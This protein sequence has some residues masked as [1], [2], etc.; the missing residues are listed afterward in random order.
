M[1]PD[2]KELVKGIC[3]FILSIICAVIMVKVGWDD[4]LTQKEYVTYRIIAVLMPIMGLVVLIRSL[5][6]Y[7]IKLYTKIF[8][9][10]AAAS[11]F[12]ILFGVMGIFM[13]IKSGRSSF[14]FFR[15]MDVL[16]VIF[17]LVV[18][19]YGAYMFV[20]ALILFIND[21][22][23]VRLIE[24]REKKW[25]SGH[26]IDEHNQLDIHFP[27]SWTLNNH[28]DFVK[29][30]FKVMRGT[31][32][33]QRNFPMLAKIEKR[34]KEHPYYLYKFIQISKIIVMAGKED[35]AGILFLRTP[36]GMFEALPKLDTEESNSQDAKRQIG[37]YEY[38]VFDITNDWDYNT[39]IFRRAIDDQ[40]LHIIMFYKDEEKEAIE[41]FLSEGFDRD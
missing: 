28:F 11:I 23:S 3:I 4:D 37:K 7:K 13:L 12:S 33:E 19:I 25:N 10:T 38:Q 8:C 14:A 16:V 24:I 18:I 40:Y 15:F 36:D 41:K 21:V 31:T 32:N 30:Q 35:E 2:K 27:E 29:L 34:I 22:K 20:S 39:Y 1:K 26:F 9:G 17:C 6:A 5:M